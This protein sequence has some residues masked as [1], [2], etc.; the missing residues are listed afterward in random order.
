MYGEDGMVRGMSCAGGLF[1]WDQEGPR[2]SGGVTLSEAIV[3]LVFLERTTDVRDAIK[4]E[5][6]LKGW[7]RMRKIELI[8]P[9]WSRQHCP[10]DQCHQRENAGHA[11]DDPLPLAQL[12]EVG[13]I[14]AFRI[15]SRQL[16]SGR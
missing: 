8:T 16:C 12:V 3:R 13:G 10:T 7:R 11:S 2:E 14:G 6:Q 5:K 9:W 4:R 15:D 1:D